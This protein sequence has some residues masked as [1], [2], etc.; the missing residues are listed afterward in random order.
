MLCIA[1]I[2]RSVPLGVN[3][4]WKNLTILDPNPNKTFEESSEEQ[5]FSY[6]L[7]NDSLPIRYDL[8]IKTDIDKEIFN[9][10]GRVK[11]H[12]KIVFPTD[13][14]TLH[15]RQLI[16]DNIDL[17]NVDHSLNQAG[18]EYNYD[19]T[20]E[21][22]KISLQ[23]NF[24]D[25]DEV[26]LDINYHGKLREDSSGFYRASYKNA[27]SG[28]KVWFATTQFQQTDARH[29][30]PCYDEPGIRAVYGLEIQHDQS[31]N[32]ISN[33]PISTRDFVQGTNYVTS[34]FQ[35]TVM[36]QSYL[37]AF[38]ISNFTFISNND[39]N[40]E[41]RIYGAP[42]RIER[43]EG[44]FALGVVGKILRKFE[45]HFQVNYPLPKMDHAAITD[46]IWGAMVIHYQK[47]FSQ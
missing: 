8:W 34:K 35:D 13:E 28:K 6:R 1:A 2:V 4:L 32:A 33:M 19:E 14:I 26:V 15:A 24:A 17:L 38:V 27:D 40:V 29:A 16:I 43:G 5:T 7:P 47:N 22:L 30:M 44:D 10:S 36:M 42:Q 21:F 23:E 46:Y 31:L 18:L 39:V 3:H 37:L 45:D 12:I 20:V 41:Q 11:I 25:N 9:F